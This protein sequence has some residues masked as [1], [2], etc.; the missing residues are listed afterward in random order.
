MRRP[1]ILLCGIAVLSG[2]TAPAPSAESTDEASAMGDY[3]DLLALFEE[4]R[5]FEPPPL[6]EGVPDY[7]EPTNAVRRDRL[8]ELQARLGAI[9]PS[10][11][12]I[13]QQV[14]YHLVRAEMNGMRFHLDVLRPFARDPAFYA[15]VRTYESDTPAEEGPTIHRPIRLWEYSLWP[16]TAM[17]EPAPLAS[18]EEA[19]LTDQLRTVPPLLQ[20]ARRNLAQSDAGDLWNAGIRVVGEQADALERL[21]ERAEEHGGGA[22]LRAAIDEARE[23]TVG[24]ATWLRTEAPGRDGPSGIGAEQYTWFLRN[25]LLLPLS[26]DDEV[27]I[28][29]QEL[30]RAHTSLRLEEHNNRHL[31]ALEPVASAEEFARLQD[32]AIPDYIRFIQEED[33]VSPEPWM[34]AALRER[35][36]SYSPPE[37]RNFFAQAT[38]RDPMLLW[39][40]MY[41]WW[42]HRWM[43][44]KPHSS[45]IRSGPLL[46]NVWMSRSEGL[47]TVFEEWM[48][49]AGLYD[50]RPRA[51]EIVW[52]MLAARAARGYASLFA[53]SNE[54]T[55]EE[56]GDMHVKHTPREWMRRDLDLLGFE[57]HLYLRQPGY[58]PSYVTGGRLL[59]QTMRER[60]RQIGDEFTLS[61]FFDELNAAGVIPVSLLHWELTG[62]DWMLREAMEGGA[63]S[64]MR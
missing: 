20:Q 27:T 35:V 7:T 60:A 33:V 38:H 31:P 13:P 49:H 43:Q 55:M 62:D 14:D 63:G 47:A 21:R 24:F 50:D 42:D 51:R 45:P 30:G 10:G 64:L 46:Y 26:W 41:H 18:A 2:C 1:L 11:W 48:M 58:G 22:D 52:V 8:A 40:H 53:Q 34:E 9:D 16:R 6:E 19:R 32:R 61:R 23:A 39:T 4:W 3:V 37:T 44:E 54:L 17:D 28:T 56:A 29:R 25:V 36:P 59:E 15:S 12:P 57:Q 5:E